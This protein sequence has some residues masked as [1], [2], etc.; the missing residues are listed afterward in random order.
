MGLSLPPGFQFC[1]TDQELIEFYLSNKVAGIT[2]GPQFNSFIS[3]KILYG[4]KAEGPSNLF[5]GR[6]EEYL[7]FFTEVNKKFAN[8][9]GNHMERIAGNGTW[10]IQKTTPVLD[11]QKTSIIGYR[12]PFSFIPKNKEEVEM[13]EEFVV[14]YTMN[15][16]TLKNYPPS[17][18]SSQ[19]HQASEWTVCKIR[20]MVSKNKRYRQPASSSVSSMPKQVEGRK[21]ART[22]SYELMLQSTTPSTQTS[23]QQEQKHH[24]PCAD[25]SLQQ[26]SICYDN[27]FESQTDSSVAYHQLADTAVAMIP[28]VVPN[29]P[30]FS[31][32]HQQSDYVAAQAQPDHEDAMI[33]EVVHNNLLEYSEPHQ[34][35]YFAAQPDHEDAAYY[36]SLGGFSLADLDVPLQLESEDDLCPLNMG[37][38]F[39][40]M[41]LPD[42]DDPNMDMGQNFPSMLLA[43]NDDPN[44]FPNWTMSMNMFEDVGL[45][46]SFTV[47]E[48]L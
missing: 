40:S 5:A 25:Q 46:I 27:E 20:K 19:N 33:T 17:S 34:S 44:M 14:S 2:L 7:Y 35:D 8:G 23:H 42:N 29:L 1:P 43:D 45:G 16:F 41:L 15:E 13:L 10:R 22:S 38:N 24:H 28:E 4:E 12:K 32:P 48:M 18:S 39:T 26:T 47:E 9:N 21:R 31:Q 36:E 30:E 37:Q 3:E 6:S 11:N